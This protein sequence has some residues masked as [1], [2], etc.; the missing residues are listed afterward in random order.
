MKALSEFLR[1]EFINRVD[2]VVCFNK[3]TE[4]NFRAIAAHHAGRTARCAA[5]HERRPGL[6][7]TT[8]L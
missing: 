5:G 7:W 8:S 6:R 3:L 1:P 2:E 4:E